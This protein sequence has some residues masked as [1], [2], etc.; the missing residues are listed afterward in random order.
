MKK[1]VAKWMALLTVASSLSAFTACGGGKGDGETLNVYCLEKGYGTA[2]LEATLEL[3]EEQDWVKEK[4]NNV[5]TKLSGNSEDGFAREKIEGGK[6]YNEFD[7]L[8]GV[9]LRDQEEKNFLEDMT[10]SVY[11]AEVPDEPGVKVIDKMP[12]RVQ[13]AMINYYKPARTDGKNNYT[14]LNYIDGVMGLLYNHD[15][16]VEELGLQVPVTTNEFIAVAESIQSTG[17]DSHAGNDLDTVI[18]NYASHNYWDSAY[19]VWWT[20]YEG[21]EQY[22]NFFDGYD[23]IEDK[24]DQMSVLDQPGR[25][26][27]LETFATV[28]SNYSYED[29]AQ[30]IAEPILIQNRYLRGEGI[31]HYNG[32]YFFDET[33]MAGGTDRGYDI[34]FMKLPVISSIVE[35]LENKSMTDATLAAVIREI[36]AD[37]TWDVSQ[38]KAD[39]V[40]KADYE[41]IAAARC[42]CI[43][44]SVLPQVAVIPNY[45]DNKDIAADFLRFL[46]TDKA[47]RE[48][49]IASG[50]ACLPTTYDYTSDTEVMNSLNNVSKSKFEVLQ[51]TSNYK[52]SYFVSAAH[53]RLGGAGLQAIRFNGLE[54]NFC[55]DASYRISVDDI[56]KDEKSH[57]QGSWAQLIAAARQ[58]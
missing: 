41:K 20:Q 30:N 32:D 16:L 51:G 47:I 26:K 50:G 39:G 43:S 57:Y 33:I 52:V 28:L 37:K 42:V 1:Q 14:S 27:A 24:T 56:L 21:M 10:E 38:A 6:S 18:M 36:D 9:N 25:K 55:R 17:Y 5:K 23:P 44:A 46:Y 11:Y 34:R 7:L 40:S 54:F 35:T 58:N 13:S 3:F 8:F 19:T 15:L 45:A 4:Y 29:S 48:F 31:F 12:Q 49:T 53:T 22:E 2:W